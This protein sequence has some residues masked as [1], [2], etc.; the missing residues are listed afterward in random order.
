M[1]ADGLECDLRP[2]GCG[3]PRQACDAGAP[4]KAAGTHQ[5]SFREESIPAAA[6]QH[7]G[8]S[9]PPRFLRDLAA[10][11]RRHRLRLPAGVEFIGS[12]VLRAASPSEIMEEAQADPIEAPDCAPRTG[13]VV[14]GASQWSVA[15]ESVV[16]HNSPIPVLSQFEFR[17]YS[18]RLYGCASIPRL[19]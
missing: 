4:P 17:N 5:L 14:C 7:D 6:E 3:A 18:A 15:D 12:V 13:E 11:R 9:L 19:G 10:R 1:P 16:Q 2:G 8:K